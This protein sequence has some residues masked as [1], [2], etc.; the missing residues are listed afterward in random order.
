MVNG[1]LR[2]ASSDLIYHLV[3]TLDYDPTLDTLSVAM[4]LNGALLSQKKSSNAAPYSPGVWSPS[5]YLQLLSSSTDQQAWP[6]Q[7]YFLAYYASALSATQ[8]AA[9]YA[10]GIPD[11][12]AVA[13]STTA[14]VKENGED[15]TSHYADPLFYT[16]EVPAAAV[17]SLQ[18]SVF[19]LEDQSYCANAC[20]RA[21]ATS[22]AR[23]Q[24]QTFP[25]S[26]SLL[27]FAGTPLTASNNIISRNDTSGTYLI[28]YRPN[29]NQISKPSLSVFDTFAIVALDGATGVASPTAGTVNI[30]VTPVVKPPSPL[31]VNFASIV[32]NQYQI[33]TLGGTVDARS[34]GVVSNASITLYPVAGTLY[35]VYPNS[36]ISAQRAHI[37]DKLWPGFRVAYIYE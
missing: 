28:R 30:V 11:S 23:I 29:W 22:S 12:A 27:S 19:D 1:A 17:R 2:N 5:H 14:T 15:E 24:I 35:Q 33:L 20:K 4:Y 32:A 36:S 8:V 10:A 25:S 16:R 31:P 26:G 7:L 9:N 34:S 21:S 3:V 13:L 6:G 18:L 37:S